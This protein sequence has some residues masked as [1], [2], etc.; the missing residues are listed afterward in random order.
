MKDKIKS[1]EKLAGLCEKFRKQGKKVG[2]TSGVFDLIHAG[3]VDYL[4]KAKSIC[5]I[6]IVGMN[7]D[8][9]A[10][11]FKGDN[12]PITPENERAKIIA[13]LEAVDY[14]FIFGERRNKKNIEVIKPHY[15]IK[16][17]DYSRAEL[18][19]GEVVEKLGGEVKL[20]EPA[21]LTSTS[22]VIEKIRAVR[23]IPTKTPGQ[24]KLPPS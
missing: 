7:S 3:H 13:G 14:L 11:K 19:S 17:K 2:F 10:K 6:L 20:I 23:D 24:H 21:F 22:A 4:E 5:D 18:T 1:R 8:A 12:R 16:A 15:Y 9:S